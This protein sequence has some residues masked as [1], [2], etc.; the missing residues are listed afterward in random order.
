[1]KHPF[2]NAKYPRFLHGGDYNPEQ[3]SPE[4]WREDMRLMKLAHVNAMSVG[5]FSWAALEP[6]EGRFER[7]IGTD[8]SSGAVSVA[9]GNG[10]RLAAS[11]TAAVEWREGSLLAPVAGER[12]LPA[13]RSAP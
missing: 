11:L 9:R 13:A 12:A 1:M 4:I 10:E 3:W 7:V 5:I 6:S 8:V 2:V